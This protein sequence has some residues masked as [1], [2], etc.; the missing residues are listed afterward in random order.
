MSRPHKDSDETLLAELGAVLHRV[1]PAPQHVEAAAKAILGWRR[2]DADL[3]ELL[4]D[5]ALEAEALAG[6]RGAGDVRHLSFG[7]APVE[8]D[9]EV[10][11]GDGRVTVLG[12]LAPGEPAQVAVR[13]RD[14]AEPVEVLAADALG[15]F[16]FEVVAGTTFRLVVSGHPAAAGGTIV[17]DWVQV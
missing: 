5:S 7:S 6:T 13:V 8:L 15:R 3:A 12:Q 11:Q 4:A 2:L 16:R 17:T 10:H 14:E 9:L 1:D